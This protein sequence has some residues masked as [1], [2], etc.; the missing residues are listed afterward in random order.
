MSNDSVVANPKGVVVDRDKLLG[1]L[2]RSRLELEG[3]HAADRDGAIERPFDIRGGDRRAV[4]E[5][6]VLAQF[7]RRRHVAEVPGLGEFRLELGIVVMIVAVFVFS[8]A[9]S[10]QPVVAVPRRLVTGPVR[11]DAHDVEVVG[12]ALG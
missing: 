9:V 7:K 10:H 8:D 6:R 11:A 2:Q 12:T 1:F 3:R 5:S 4:V